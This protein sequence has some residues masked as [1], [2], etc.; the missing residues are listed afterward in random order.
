MKSIK[1][2]AAAIA[3]AAMGL[4]SCGKDDPTIT[5]NDIENTL[6]GKS[7]LIEEIV[8]KDVTTKLLPSQDFDIA[9]ND[10]IQLAE[11][12]DPKLSGVVFASAAPS[13]V[14]VDNTGK[15]KMIGYNPE[16]DYITVIAL[17]NGKGIA[18]YDF[19]PMGKGEATT[20]EG[21]TAK[22]VNCNWCEYYIQSNNRIS[23]VNAPSHKHNAMLYIRT[24]KDEFVQIDFAEDEDEFVWDSKKAI[25]QSCY[26]NQNNYGNNP[27]LE[28][29]VENN[30]IKLTLTAENN[31]EEKI[32]VKYEGPLTKSEE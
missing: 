15:A 5:Y 11:I 1:Y 6:S 20:G 22:T 25:F 8:N 29:S 3:I 19:W 31:N 2:T 21:N 10:E 16:Y 28:F 12:S 27:K 14:A 4:A 23:K 17:Y 32:S 26:Y 24:E 18:E 13:I 30:I 7:E 9:Y